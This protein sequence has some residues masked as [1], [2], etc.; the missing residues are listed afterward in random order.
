MQTAH[1]MRRAALAGATVLITSAGT[2]EAAVLRGTVVHRNARAHSFTIA[3]RAGRLFAVHASHSPSVGS[4]V[5]ISARRLRN[6]T[7]ALRQARVVARRRAARTRLRGVVTYVDRRDGSFTLSAI[8]VSMLVRTGAAGRAR[9]ADALP[10]VGDVVSATG[11]VDD[12]GELDAQS[13]QVE[14]VDSQG[15]DLEGTVL[16]VDATA[17]TITVSSTDDDRTSGSLTVTVPSSMDISL[18][19]V[20]EEVELNVAIASDGSYVLLGSASDQGS[21]GAQSQSQE[22]GDQPGDQGADQGDQSGDQGD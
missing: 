4:I 13:V 12:Q 21:Q 3:N 16:A 17:G 20:G 8:G 18:F 2:A 9:I 10:A 19:S 7:W 15:I 1:I 6:G 14:G 22:Q 5:R 11:V